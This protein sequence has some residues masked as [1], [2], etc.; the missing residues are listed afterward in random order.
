LVYQLSEI[1]SICILKKDIKIVMI[2]VKKPT[3]KSD[4]VW[5]IQRSQDSDFIQGIR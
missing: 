2:F 1:S 4:Y 3:V 5:M